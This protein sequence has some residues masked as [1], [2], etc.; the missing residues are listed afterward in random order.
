MSINLLVCRDA[1]Q[2]LQPGAAAGYQCQFCE[3]PL[4]VSPAGQELIRDVGLANVTIACNPCGFKAAVVAES[5]GRL[6]GVRALPSAQQQ[7]EKPGSDANPYIEWM[8]K[9]KG[10]A[11]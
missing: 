3:E 6:D 9:H 2:E 5:H 10:G 11:A 4:A 1:R 8:K 7:M